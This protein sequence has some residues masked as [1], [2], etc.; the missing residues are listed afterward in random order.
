MRTASRAGCEVLIVGLAAGASL[1]RA[2]RYAV[3]LH[4][5]M[6][7]PQSLLAKLSPW[8][9]AH[10]RPLPH[11]WP[12]SLSMLSFGTR[13]GGWPLPS[14]RSAGVGGLPEPVPTVSV[15]GPK[16]RRTRRFAHGH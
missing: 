15:D 7:C 8:P 4:A 2:P 16:E 14:R 6:R 13:S 3:C 5:I 10:L 11:I 9:T 12:Y 1:C